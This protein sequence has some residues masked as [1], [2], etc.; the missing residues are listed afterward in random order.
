MEKIIKKM[1]TS[2]SNKK[3]KVKNELEQFS[4]EEFN[5]EDFREL[6]VSNSDSSKSTNSESEE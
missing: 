1:K 6:A 5:Y 2:N 3:K 4:M